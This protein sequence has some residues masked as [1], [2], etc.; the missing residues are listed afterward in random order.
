[1]PKLVILYWEPGSGGDFVQQLLLEQPNQYQG[2]VEEFVLTEQGRLY[3]KLK[4]FFIDNFEN[5]YDQWYLRKWSTSDCA[6]LSKF[7]STLNCDCFVV[8]THHYEQL[9][10]LQSQFN[11]SISIG[12]QYPKNMFPL[13]LKNWC[14]KFASNRAV[15]Q[16]RYN[17]P[18]HQALKNRNIFGEF[19]LSEQLK[20]N[21]VAKDYV[22][23]TFDVSISL[24]NLYSYNISV[25]HN[26]FPDSAHV[27]K[28]YNNWISKQNPLHRYCYHIPLLLQHA[29]GHNSQAA[30]T[31]NNDLTLDAYDN[32]L[33]KHHCNTQ[34]TLKSIPNFKTLQQAADF[35]EEHTDLITTSP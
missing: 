9:E 18:F 26:L 12:I 13:V 31:G 23:Q 1:M 21:S 27:D 4:K 2:I 20:C 32:I 24:E 28:M 25:L 33:I 6:V 15:V 14:K 7:I 34:T 30:V 29:L 10:F 8:P 5:E 3:P 16:E 11:N 22:D 35:F 17:Q 19:I